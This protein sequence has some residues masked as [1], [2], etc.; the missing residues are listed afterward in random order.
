MRHDPLQPLTSLPQHPKI[1]PL[2]P[3]PPHEKIVKRLS[4]ARKQA[5][6]AKW[7]SRRPHC[8]GTAY[9]QSSMRAGAQRRLACAPP[10]VPVRPRQAGARQH[11]G[12]GWLKR[13]DS[14]FL[15]VPYLHPP[16]FSL[17]HRD[18]FLRGDSRYIF[19]DPHRALRRGAPGEREAQDAAGEAAPHRGGPRA[20]GQ[21]RPQQGRARLPRGG[22]DANARPL[23]RLEGERD[24]GRRSK[25][26]RKASSRRC[27]SK[28]GAAFPRSRGPA[29]A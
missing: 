25:S 9:G 24:K 23:T 20:G 2:P 29:A 7:F 22:P 1:S 18:T 4:S 10:A 16:V 11:A 12:V 15:W 6:S 3:E 17:R 13:A 26:V 27:S 5:V 21:L 8:F 28:L 14:S 19:R